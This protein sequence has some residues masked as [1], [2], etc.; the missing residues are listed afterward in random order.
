[1]A[2]NYNSY[3]LHSLQERLQCKFFVWFVWVGFF[4]FFF[5]LFAC[6]FV[7]VCF[8]C[9]G[10][11]LFL[12]WFGF[13][14]FYLVGFFGGFFA[15]QIIQNRLE[16]CKKSKSFIGMVMHEN[17]IL[18][19]FLPKLWKWIATS[20]FQ[21]IMKMLWAFLNFVF[22]AVKIIHNQAPCSS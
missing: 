17:I 22:G 4:L 2:G 6:F 16:T 12:V 19:I 7:V 10:F 9:L 20:T 15:P 11:F 21:S 1:M 5:F 13:G 18:E 8:I 14:L 3:Y